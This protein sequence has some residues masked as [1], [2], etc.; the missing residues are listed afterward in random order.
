M[1]LAEAEAHQRKHGFIP[2]C[3]SDVPTGPPAAFKP[4][5]GSKEPNKT[6]A[7]YG[8]LLQARKQRDEIHS[9]FYE[10]LTLR[11]GDGM[12]YTPDYVVYRMNPMVGPPAL[13]EVKGGYIW[14]RDLV[15][16]KGCKAE[17]KDYFRFELWQK[18][19]GVWTRLL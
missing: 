5:R 9:Y 18:K 4:K 12:R 11:W 1:S 2:Q 6:E 13:V 19:Q 10:G 8:L 15:R 7:S 17:W 3:P 16:F 14:D